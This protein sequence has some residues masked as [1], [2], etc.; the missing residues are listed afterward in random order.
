M[1]KPKKQLTAPTPE[2]L[3]INPK[4]ESPKW[5]CPVI[6]I[7]VNRNWETVEVEKQVKE[8][9]AGWPWARVPEKLLTQAP[10][11]LN[12][13]NAETGFFRL[14]QEIQVI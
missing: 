13:H 11:A 10:Y 8:A 7:D 6:D 9:N 2:Y 14:P 5:E 12:E 4:D 3:G 1:H